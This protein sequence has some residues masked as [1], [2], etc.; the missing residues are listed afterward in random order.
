MGLGWGWGDKES[1]LAFSNG[2]QFK[3]NDLV[4]VFV[5]TEPSDRGLKQYPSGGGS[6][7]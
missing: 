5:G 4:D 7:E 6:K 3:L 2:L 1:F